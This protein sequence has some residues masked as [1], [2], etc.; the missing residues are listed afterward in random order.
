MQNTNFTIA[1]YPGDG[2]GTEIMATAEAVLSAAQA[3]T[4]GFSLSLNT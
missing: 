2:I 3:K 1:A 4:G